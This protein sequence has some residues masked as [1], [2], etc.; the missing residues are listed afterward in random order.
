MPSY[1]RA[2]DVG[3]I[4]HTFMSYLNLKNVDDKGIEYEF[5]RMVNDEFMEKSD[6]DVLMKDKLIN[7]CKSKLAYD[8]RRS[9]EC[10]KET[11]FVKNFPAE[12][13]T[14]NPTRKEK[15]KGK[16]VIV[17]GQL[18]LLFKNEKDEWILVDYK[19]D[20]S[21]R[22]Y[23]V[24][25]NLAIRVLLD[26]HSLQLSLYKVACEELFN[27]KIAHTLL[28]SFAIDDTIELSEDRLDYI[29]NL[30]RKYNEKK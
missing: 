16:D 5:E 30:E 9:K 12:Y 24:D 25:R 10:Y 6:V 3:T 17:Q 15:L 7:F 29:K 18:D 28:Y 4:M 1:R 23:E 19:T 27:I 11:R 8:L 13:F 26:R 22:N 14:N 20:Y 2:S 21:G